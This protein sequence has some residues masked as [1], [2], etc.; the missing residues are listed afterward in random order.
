M[1]KVWGALA[2]V[3]MLGGCVSGL[4]VSEAQLD[5]VSR[6]CAEQNGLTKGFYTARYKGSAYGTSYEVLPGRY[7]TTKLAKRINACIAAEI[8][9]IEAVQGPGGAPVTVA[10]SVRASAPAVRP[11]RSTSACTPGGNVISGGAGYCTR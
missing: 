9:R 10:P 8:E 5:A 6:S 7:V 2:A 3:A 11:A 1:D 4:R